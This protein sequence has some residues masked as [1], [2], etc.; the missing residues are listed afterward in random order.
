MRNASDERLKGTIGYIADAPQ[1]SKPWRTREADHS[2]GGP[3]NGVDGDKGISLGTCVFS[4]V[5]LR[6]RGGGREVCRRLNLSSDCIYE[7]ET[8]HKDQLTNEVH[9]C[10]MHRHGV[11]IWVVSFGPE[12]IREELGDD[13]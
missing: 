13:E 11:R 7:L 9:H 6:G 2:D 1:W 8:D 5:P 12:E 4:W 3:D 10:R